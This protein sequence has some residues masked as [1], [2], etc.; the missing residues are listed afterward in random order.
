[1]NALPGWY[2]KLPGAGD[3]SSRRLPAAFIQAWDTWLQ[4]GLSHATTALGE[5]W[6][7]VYFVA[8]IW[9][10]WLLPGLLDVRGWAGL[11]MPSVDRVG[12]AFP[13]T[14]AWPVDTLPELMAQA[15]HFTAFD[16]AARSALDV[17]VG[18]DDFEAGLVSAAA[19][20]RR[21]PSHDLQAGAAAWQQTAAA[22]RS[23]WWLG[24]TGPS[25]RPRSFDGLPA[26]T[27]FVTLLEGVA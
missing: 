10:F 23:L 1:M 9:R 6:L 2:G 18:I 7:E 25:T 15:T 11:M 26:P 12:R 19:V 8:P 14:L 5:D 13:L 24:E 16:D 27:A 3:F 20:A 21:P 22:A 17:D 4:D